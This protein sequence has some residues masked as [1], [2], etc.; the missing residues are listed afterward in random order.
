MLDGREL[1]A[2]AVAARLEDFH[3]QP[4]RFGPRY[5]YGIEPLPNG[6]IVLRFAQ[7]KFPESMA[8]SARESAKL[9]AAALEFVRR[10]CLWDLADHY[11]ALC[12]RRDAAPEAVKENYHLLMALLHPDRQEGGS[13]EWP[14]S[15]AQR[16]NLAYAVLGEETS[17]REYDAQLLAV[18]PRVRAPMAPRAGRR[19]ASELRFAKAVVAI[20]AVMAALI[21]VSL[22]VDDDERGDRSILEAS[23]ARLR[24][25]PAPGSDRPRYVGSSVASSP[26]AS[27]A[28]YD[29]PEPFAL[30]KPLM[31]A[32]AGEEPKAWVPPPR[33]ETP[34]PV[35]RASNSP[36]EPLRFA[37]AP[38]P[39]A[40]REAPASAPTLRATPVLRTTPAVASVPAATPEKSRATNREIENLV[41][42]LVDSYQAGDTD[43]LVG[44][45]EPEAGFWRT[46]RM[47]QAYADFFRAT[48]ARRLRIEKLAWNAQTG[49]AQARGEATVHAEYFDQAAAVERRVEMELDI[50]LR[51]GEARIRRLS[52]FPDA[53]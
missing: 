33:L 8:L 50:V 25:Q 48:R 11:Q 44:L 4:E 5:L 38:A 40:A 3:A 13:E 52:L 27:D 51:D 18:Q 14:Q 42:A 35:I 16:V 36:A 47:R 32:I 24:T 10:I 43:R 12:A 39:S 9:R 53:R 45:L 37:Q 15:C 28:T 49:T 21:G 19:P 23:L 2:A 30:L 31:R 41:V 29:D 17:R 7:G 6:R 1:E 26:R 34:P 46:Q 20:G 22:A